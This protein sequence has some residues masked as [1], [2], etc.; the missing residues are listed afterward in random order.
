MKA[1]WDVCLSSPRKAERLT[2]RLGRFTSVCR[3]IGPS[4]RI[5]AVARERDEV[6][7]D[8]TGSTCACGDAAS[9]VGELERIA[10]A[11]T[12]A[13]PILAAVNERLAE[14]DEGRPDIRFAW[15]SG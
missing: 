15:R 8:I 2:R 3:L 10:T 14:L 1:A 9:V 13:D 4:S 6:A 12:P 5:A 11:L 7:S